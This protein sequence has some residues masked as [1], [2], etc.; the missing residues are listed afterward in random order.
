MLPGGKFF[1]AASS[2]SYGSE[3]STPP[4]AAR[5]QV[6]LAQAPAR[7]TPAAIPASLS[8][9]DLAACDEAD[10]GQVPALPTTTTTPSTLKRSADGLFFK[11]QVAPPTAPPASLLS[12]QIRRSPPFEGRAAAT[13]TA[14]ASVPVL[15][16]AA[17]SS[18]DR[19]RT[20]TSGSGALAMARRPGNELRRSTSPPVLIE[21]TESLRRQLLHERTPV[22]HAP[23]S[24]GPAP[25][26]GTSPDAPDPGVFSY[27]SK[28]VGW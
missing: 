17:V 5:R 16:A 23:V 21:G 1:I 9:E 7:T 24:A 15:P 2:S 11:V 27:R 3:E 19:R 25:S 13:T 6:P 26:W 18:S 20:G 8:E 4:P 14:A 12:A 22:P 28:V 10:D